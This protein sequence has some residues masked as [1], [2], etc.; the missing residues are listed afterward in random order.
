MPEFTVEFE[1]FCATCGAG[2]CSV[3][4]GGNSPRR[5]HPFVRV[6]P[7]A[8]CLEKAEDVAADRAYDRG[9]ADAETAAAKES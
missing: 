1:V 9:Y 7:C 2:L 8:A 3:S 6:E 5:R 4:E